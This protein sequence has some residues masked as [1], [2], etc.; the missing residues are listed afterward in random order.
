MA[1]VTFDELLD[2]GVHF[3]HLSRKWNPNMAPYIFG[4]KKES[5]LLILIRQQ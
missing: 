1:K 2:S 3:G 4:E 5:T